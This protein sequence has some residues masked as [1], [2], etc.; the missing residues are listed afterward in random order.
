AA[1]IADRDGV[2]TAILAEAGQVVSAGQPVVEVA[3]D[4][5]RE[6]E[7]AVPESRVAEVRDARDLSVSLWSDPT[8]LY[9]GSLRELAPDTDDKTRTY[10]ARISIADAD[11]AVLLGL[12]ASVEIDSA[13][14]AKLPHIPLSAVVSQPDGP[15]VWVVDP[16]TWTVSARDVTLE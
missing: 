12:S 11:D 10:A 5:E 14:D 15:Q 16:A 8:H 7:I 3:G 6:V 2:V 13:G 9:S 1:L 4:G